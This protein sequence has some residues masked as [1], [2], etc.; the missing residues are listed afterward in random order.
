MPST[1]G[2]WP[3]FG[4]S[5]R[6]TPRLGKSRKAGDL[7]RLAGVCINGGACGLI[8]QYTGNLT[9]RRLPGAQIFK[10]CGQT[11]CTGAAWLSSVRVSRCGIELPNEHNP[12]QLG[13]L[14]AQYSRLKRGVNWERLFG[15]DSSRPKVYSWKKSSQYGLYR[16]GYTRA[17]RGETTGRDNESFSKTPN[18]L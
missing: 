14:L 13:L 4:L 8:R 11:R 5:L 1:M 9:N 18:P 17:T 3:I 7:M 2:V 16:L 15:L 6:K 10:F 12:P